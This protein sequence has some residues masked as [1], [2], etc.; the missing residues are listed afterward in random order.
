MAWMVNKK[1]PERTARARSAVLAIT[2]STMFVA[3]G[4]LAQ[5]RVITTATPGPQVSTPAAPAVPTA[6]AT[7]QSATELRRVR[8][9]ESLMAISRE[10]AAAR[11]VTLAQAMVGLY[12]VNP[13]AF[14]GGDMSQLLVGAELRLPARTE[15]VTVSRAAAFREV[16]QRLGIWGGAPTPAPE[17]PA[18]PV[19]ESAGPTTSEP[20]DTAAEP[21][22]E[23]DDVTAQTATQQ[24][25]IDS[26]KQ[27]LEEA[28]AELE[29]Q[30]PARVSAPSALQERLGNLW[31]LWGVA[32]AVIAFLSILL[33]GQSR[34][35]Q[36]AEAQAQQ[37]DLALA[38]LHREREE[39]VLEVAA[40]ADDADAQKGVEV[41]DSV[42]VV[43]R[44]EVTEAE[45]PTEPAIS[46]QADSKLSF[47]EIMSA[48]EEDLEGDPPPIEEAG[49]MIDL[50]RA[51]IEMGDH[52]A[53]MTELQLAL[54]NGN[55]AQRAEALRLLD[56]LPKS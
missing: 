37:A 13:Q 26:L 55:E 9:G 8:P 16:Q 50:A 53:A 21:P 40:V 30:I 24:A 31:W 5:Q 25:E 34:R 10:L 56:S 22:A 15:L 54:K 32:L 20:A 41:D 23:P 49:S 35:A 42:A 18:A 46:A 19:A 39:G 29:T 11:D 2:L 43:D 36:E 27:A 51:Y 1:H 48:N 45:D 47:S 6:P 33:R 14:V 44:A 38:R 52:N 17:S 28:R 7:A 3:A 12:R 4:A